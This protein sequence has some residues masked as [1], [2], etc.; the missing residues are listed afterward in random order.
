VVAP[1]DLE[2]YRHDAMGASRK[3]D[4]FVGDIFGNIYNLNLTGDRRRL[5]LGGGLVDK[6][7]DNETERDSIT[8]GEDFGTIT[9]L[10]SRPDGLYV[11]NLDGELYRIATLGTP[12]PGLTGD[13]SEAMLFTRSVPEPGSL[14]MVGLGWMLICWRR[15]R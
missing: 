14:V 9:D 2:F 3:N 11:L 8:F 10:I 12:G 13:S 7:I 4:L 1:T 6:V 15:R 5:S